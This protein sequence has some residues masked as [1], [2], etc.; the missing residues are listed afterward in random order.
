MGLK[1]EM[2]WAKMIKKKSSQSCYNWISIKEKLPPY[3]YEILVYHEDGNKS[4]LFY[5]A[6]TW[7]D[8]QR[9]YSSNPITHWMLTPE[10]PKEEK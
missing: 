8:L 5:W 2:E 9:L 10:G 7:E 4:V 3:G 1:E 6:C